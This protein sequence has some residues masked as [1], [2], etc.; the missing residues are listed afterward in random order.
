MNGIRDITNE[1]LNTKQSKQFWSNIQ[2]N[3]KKHERNA[4]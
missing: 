3:E 4:E 2:N 1:K